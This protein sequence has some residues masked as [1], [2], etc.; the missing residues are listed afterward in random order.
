MKC[1]LCEKEAT[2]VFSCPVTNETD[3]NNILNGACHDSV[4]TCNICKESFNWLDDII[5]E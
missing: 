2:F 1:P 5:V 3:I 4:V